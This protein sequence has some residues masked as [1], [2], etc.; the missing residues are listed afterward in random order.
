MTASLCKAIVL[1]INVTELDPT[2]SGYP[3]LNYPR[4]GIELASVL[5]IMTQF[6]RIRKSRK[7][8]KI[9]HFDMCWFKAIP[10]LPST[11]FFPY[12]NGFWLFLLLLL[13][14]HL[15]TCYSPLFSKLRGS[16]RGMAV[17][18]RREVDDGVRATLTFPSKVESFPFFRSWCWFKRSEEVFDPHR[19]N[20]K[21]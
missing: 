1:P 7:S 11:I 4:S 5:A 13:L 17:L 20:L 21:I 15:S 8:L 9:S 6:W 18:I 2:N 12:I 16:T 10:D 3:S 14:D 19:K